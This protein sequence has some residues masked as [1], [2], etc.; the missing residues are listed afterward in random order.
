MTLSKKVT[1]AKEDF[2]MDVNALKYATTL[3]NT[4]LNDSGLESAVRRVVISYENYI[5]SKIEFTD[6]YFKTK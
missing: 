6:E 5:N 1:Q 3:T 2:I 4:E